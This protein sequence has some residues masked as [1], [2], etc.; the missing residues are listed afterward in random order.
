[1]RKVYNRDFYAFEIRNYNFKKFLI[2][3]LWHPK[4]TYFQS[5]TE[6]TLYINFLIKD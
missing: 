6:G 5:I 3:M 2:K 1:M 4:F